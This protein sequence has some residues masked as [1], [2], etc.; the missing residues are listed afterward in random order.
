[1][2]VTTQLRASG[3]GSRTARA[4]T[5]VADRGVIL[6]ALG[7]I[8]VRLVTTIAT[9]GGQVT[10]AFE[11][12]YW[13]IDWSQG[14]IRR[15]LT[16]TVLEPIPVLRERAG[17]TAV[18]LAM[19]VVCLAVW[20]TVMWQAVARGGRPTAA[21]AIVALAS[22]AGLLFLITQKRPDQLGLI[23]LCVYGAV[24]LRRPAARIE[25][26]AS[27]VAGL[28]LG[29]TA[30]VHE[31]I[32]LLFL[33]FLFIVRTIR[34]RDDPSIVRGDAIGRRLALAGPSL[35]AIAVIVLR[36]PVTAAQS[37]ALLDAAT[38]AGV[39][40]PIGTTAFD[41]AGMYQY[42]SD[43]P[44]DISRRFAESI[45]VRGVAGF[46]VLAGIVA[47]LMAGALWSMRDPSTRPAG[48]DLARFRRWIAPLDVGVLV[49]AYAA[50]FVTAIDWWR[51]S[52]WLALGGLTTF[53]L[54]RLARTGT[55]SVVRRR[56]HPT[57]GF[58]VGVIGLLWLRPLTAV[59]PGL[60]A[61]A[62]LLLGR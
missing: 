46:V 58:A 5:W 57:V 35:V 59:P 53:Q 16:G 25:T 43:G 60:D 8:A 61:A 24:V 11:R 37:S 51:W 10:S 54:S 44:G 2:S 48:L 29:I 30:L 3:T 9:T 17:I 15:G 20:L 32:P 26:I 22:P 56:L 23:V 19:T 47:A 45:G 36:G 12:S 62:H 1:M 55:A 7:V 38:G 28:A 40:D 6:T 50:L 13:T 42:L 49:G 4:R 18:V 52:C 33:P 39:V 31:A 41:N 34:E 14:F 21:V 27:V